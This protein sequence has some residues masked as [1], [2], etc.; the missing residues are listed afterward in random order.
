MSCVLAFIFLILF[1]LSTFC[2]WSDF[3]VLESAAADENY[4]SS[5]VQGKAMMALLLW[6]GFV[7]NSNRLV[8]E[9]ELYCQC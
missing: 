9:P 8:L 6:L 2:R 4:S 7:C 1:K 3:S 5:F